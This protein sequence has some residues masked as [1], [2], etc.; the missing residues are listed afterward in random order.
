MISSESIRLARHQSSPLAESLIHFP[1]ILWQYG[2]I[3]RE[4]LD[5]FWSGLEHN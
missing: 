5:E 2:L 1:I 3:R 4:K